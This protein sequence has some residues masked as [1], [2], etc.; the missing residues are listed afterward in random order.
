MEKVTITFNKE[1]FNKN[2]DEEN[3]ELQSSFKYNDKIFIKS[4]IEILRT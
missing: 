1:P 4:K 2:Y 3:I